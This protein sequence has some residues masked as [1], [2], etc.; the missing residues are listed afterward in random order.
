MITRNRDIHMFGAPK[1]RD[2]LSLQNWI[3]GNACISRK[4]TS[5]LTHTFDLLCA[6]SISNDAIKRV[7]EFLE[8]G[9]IRF[10]QPFRKVRLSAAREVPSR[11][12]AQHRFPGYPAQRLE[13]PARFHLLGPILETHQSLDRDSRHSIS[14]TSSCHHD[15]DPR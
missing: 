11:V 3:A 1:W 2:I 6:R 13:R 15:H 12:H 4:E 9:L 5:Y 7:Q 8:A 10:Y 14:H